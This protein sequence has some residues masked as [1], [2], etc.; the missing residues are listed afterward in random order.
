V[1]LVH[2]RARGV[3]GSALWEFSSVIAQSP[4]ERV[5]DRRVLPGARWFSGATL[6]YAEHSLA[7]ARRPTAGDAPAIVF[8]S[9]T[10][11]RTEISWAAPAAQVGALAATVKHLGVAPGDRVVSYLPNIPE[12]VAALF[13]AASLGAVWSSCSPDMGPVSV[14]DR[15]RQ[16]GPKVLFVVDGY[17]YG[18]KP[19]DRRETVRDLVEKLPSL[20]AVVFLSFAEATRRPAPLEFTP[21]QGPGGYSKVTEEPSSGASTRRRSLNV[22]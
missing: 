9:E 13:A 14:L 3:L 16:I 15:F 21:D 12:T 19:Y 18:G 8:Q 5:L 22:L 1:A 17:R 11:P 20:Q 6:N 2:D 7:K 4:Y 10:R